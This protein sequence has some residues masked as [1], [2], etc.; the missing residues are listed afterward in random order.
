MS[1]CLK[2]IL[3]IIII[4]FRTSYPYGLTICLVNS[5]YY[6]RFNSY[7]DTDSILD[8]NAVKE[9]ELNELLLDLMLNFEERCKLFD[10]Y[11]AEID[12]NS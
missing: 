11:E 1:V 12:N 6:V 10:K 4:Q 5:F 9:K 8:I 2:S 7:T 3:L